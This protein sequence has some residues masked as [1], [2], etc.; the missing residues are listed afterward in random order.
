M[1]NLSAP[2]HLLLLFLD[3]NPQKCAPKSKANLPQRHFREI[4][5]PAIEGISIATLEIMITP[6]P[7]KEVIKRILDL[8]LLRRSQFVGVSALTI[9]AAGLLI[10]TLPPETFLRP[11]FEELNHIIMS[12]A[13]LLEVS[14]PCRLVT[15]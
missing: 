11:V 8:T 2:S 13:N 9:H 7:P 3:M 1:A 14:E 4:G 6:I 10:S 5:S 15:L 12:D